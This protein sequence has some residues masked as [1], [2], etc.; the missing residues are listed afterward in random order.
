MNNNNNNNNNNSTKAGSRR[1]TRRRINL[2][3]VIPAS[4]IIIVSCISISLYNKTVRTGAEAFSAAYSDSRDKVSDEISREFYNAALVQYKP[5]YST[6]TDMET[7][8]G[9]LEVFRV[10]D[11]SYI[12]HSPAG[13]VETP[14]YIEI[15]CSGIYTV[16]MQ[17]SEII[18]DEQRKHVTV[19]IPQPELTDF[20][21]EFE[22]A[23]LIDTSGIT[24]SSVGKSASEYAHEA[25]DEDDPVLMENMLANRIFTENAEEAAKKIL[26]QA[27]SA[28]NP[29]LD[30]TVEVEFIN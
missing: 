28:R 5:V 21:V 14:F 26:V 15:P 12:P 23:R 10:S 16:N 18:N 30:I 20:T 19:R 11:I 27:I 7:E 9:L 29:F 13:G 25:A 22:S 1:R 8:N 17:N 6:V 3:A 2:T 24:I 4:L